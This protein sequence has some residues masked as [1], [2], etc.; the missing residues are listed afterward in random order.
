MTCC[1]TGT[2]IVLAENTCGAAYAAGG[3]CSDVLPMLTAGAAAG[4]CSDVLPMITAG[5][6]CGAAR[7]A[8]GTA[9]GVSAARRPISALCSAS[10]YRSGL[11]RR[12]RVSMKPMLPRQ[13]S[14][15]AHRVSVS[16]AKENVTRLPGTKLVPCYGHVL[17]LFVAKV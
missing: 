7:G 9:T 8:W 4:I 1:G 13:C 14:V 16:R 17:E 3:I 10:W 12:S 6:A 2:W 11:S 5:A 15:Q